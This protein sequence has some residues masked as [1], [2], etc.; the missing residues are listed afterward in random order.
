MKP[1]ITESGSQMEGLDDLPLFAGINVEPL[2]I[3]GTVGMAT[4]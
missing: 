1:V 4:V 3:A 2:Q